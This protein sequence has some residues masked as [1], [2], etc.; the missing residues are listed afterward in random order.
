MV[1]RKIQS[2]HFYFPEECAIGS[3]L[4]DRIDAARCTLRRATLFSHRFLNLGRGNLMLQTL[5]LTKRRR[6]TIIVSAILMLL[7]SIFVFDARAQSESG[8]AAIEG[9]LTDS[10]GAA[11][12]GATVMIRN[13]ETGLERT[14]STDGSGRFTA[15]VL[16]V[17]R[18]T[19]RAEASGFAAAVN[20]DVRLSVGETTAVDFT[21]A[22]ASVQE[23][24][25]VSAE[26]ESVDAET[27]ASSST[28]PERAV[29]D[30]PIRG[31]N[32]TEFVQLTPAVVQ[33]SDRGGLVI[34]GQ[35]SI[36]SNVAIDGADYND[37]L[38]GNQRGGAETA[39]FFPQTAVR[40]FQVVRSGA[41]AEIGRTNA[42]FVNVVTKSG[43]NSFNGEAF[44]F[45]RIVV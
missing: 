28:I 32:F 24:V 9:S 36:N 17:G 29:E 4:K 6:M 20:D 14:V 5:T 7:A 15:P 19:V 37:A 13:T 12:G 1:V 42:G 8:S 38:Q 22:P 21:I 10:N 39:F 43:T 44:Y 23:Q 26:A 41:N 27:Q 35:R 30:L 16:P 40:E 45:N 18:Y 2:T 25:T 3:S 33:E 31:R 34:A 11:I